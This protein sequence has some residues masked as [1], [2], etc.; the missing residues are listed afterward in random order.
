M[1]EQQ[2]ADFIRRQG[3][4]Y[5]AH[6]LRR[7]SDEFVRGFEGWNDE[8]GLCSHPRTRSTL[9]SLSEFGELGVTEIAGMIRQSH[10]LVITWIRQ[11]K[12]LGLISS[13]ACAENRRITLIRLTDAGKREV[14]QMRK[15][16]QLVTRAYLQ[17]LKDADVPDD[18]FEALWRIEATCR[19]RSMQ[20]RLS[21]ASS[22]ADPELRQP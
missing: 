7:L 14:E 2:H 9:L 19:D 17:L 5:L 22:E 12:E 16:D 4:P 13:E 6:L 21:R 1:I 3:L 10:P 15:T 18:L 20:E 11:L 8:A